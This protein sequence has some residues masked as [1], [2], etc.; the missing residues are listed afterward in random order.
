MINFAKW[1]GGAAGWAF[2]EWLSRGFGWELGGLIGGLLGFVGGTV[3]DSFEI[4]FRKK[5]NKPAMG[6][7]S[8]NLLILIAAVMK[9]DGPVVKSELEYAKQFLKLNYGEKET[10]KALALLNKIRKLDDSPDKACT[11]VHHHLDQSSKLQLI[12]FLYNLANIDGTASDAEQ[13]L[14][15]RITNTLR[16][17]ISDDRALGRGDVREKE[18]IMAYAT[19]GID[20]NDSIIDIKK[21]YRTLANKCHPDKVAFLDENQKQNAKDQF[22]RLAGAYEIIKKDKRFT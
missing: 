15:K 11:Y 7:F 8:T 18:I 6:D 13:Q 20:R 3:I 19:L 12:H 17:N 10:P 22:Q 2:G 5:D 4:R 21:A 9:V 16:V 1:I 14:L